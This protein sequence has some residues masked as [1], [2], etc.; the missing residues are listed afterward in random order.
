M[1][2]GYCI[3]PLLSL[4]GFAWLAVFTVRF[5]AAFPGR[6]IFLG[7]CILG[8]FLYIDVL[9]IFSVSSERIALWVSRIDHIFILYLIPLYLQFFSRYLG[10]D[11]Y[12]GLIRIIY[13]AAGMLMLSAPTDWLIRG[14]K[15]YDFGY[16][17][18]GGHLYWLVGLCAACS[19]AIVFSMLLQAIRNESR[20]LYRIKLVYMAIG[21]AVLGLL[22]GLNTLP[23]LG[24]SIYPPGNFAFIP[25]T[26]FAFGL[27]RYDL[28]GMNLLVRRGLLYGLSSLVLSAAYATTLWVL[29]LIFPA[30]SN[31]WMLLITFIFFFGVGISI[32][33]LQSW[34][35][36]RIDSLIGKDAGDY[37]A[38]I[39]A[40]SRDIVTIQESEVIVGL[41]VKT[42][43]SAMNLTACAFY[44]GNDVTGCFEP[45]VCM[46]K[47]SVR[48]PEQ[49]YCPQ[50][51][52]WQAFQNHPQVISAG[53][54]KSRLEKKA[55][56]ALL[57]DFAVLGASLIVPLVGRQ[58]LHGLLMVS[59]KVSGE[60][61]T[62][63]DI[64][65]LDILASQ[66]ALALENAASIEQVRALNLELEKKVEERTRS[67]QEA[68]EKTKQMQ[69][70]MIRSESLAS[71]GTLVAGTAHELNN[72]LASADSLI[73][74]VLEELVDQPDTDTEIVSDL[75]FARKQLGKAR[76][77]IRSLLGLSRQNSDNTEMVH[78]RDVVND[79]L[80][81]LG[82]RLKHSKIRIE[83]L[84][85]PDVPAIQGRFS[86]LGQLV[87]N[88]I[89]NAFHAVDP[90]KGIVRIQVLVDFEGKRIIFDC[91][92]NGP[93]V[94]P[95]L[96]QSIFKPFFTTKAPGKGTG[97]GLYICHEIAARHG[98][99]ITV[100]D[101]P[102]GGARFRVTFPGARGDA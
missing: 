55:E 33:P 83:T 54:A 57:S 49:A 91:D 77:I 2:V 50:A 23:I 52:L 10:I 93:G 17:A 84:L 87:L 11:R 29:H 9:L 31:I 70:Q 44:R 66:S 79:A 51:I 13:A 82:N 47:E 75:E 46:Q 81:V 102:L 20:A 59:D 3:P 37:P 40:L 99:E 39:L 7:I 45:T 100:D 71:I 85:A 35:R 21:F 15:R 34:L 5:G 92:D 42:V 78:L 65:L 76:E 22:I 18:A 8:C 58:R 97:L 4:I 38:V 72:P 56:A 27:F 36:N 94:H 80:K 96:R 26:I 95:E 98:A 43:Y 69:E 6:N 16:W 88:L 62:A 48:R 89:D 60:P 67:L 41:L 86:E 101:S 64:K 14:M 63:E 19:T 73:Q 25:L 32:G 53:I 24:L 12:R 90:E 1:S 68:L 30:S 74:S 28:L 61:F